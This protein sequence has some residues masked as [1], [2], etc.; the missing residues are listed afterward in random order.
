MHLFANDKCWPR[1]ASTSA[2]A[3]RSTSR[4]SC[5]RSSSSPAAATTPT[6]TPRSRRSRTTWVR[7][8]SPRCTSRARSTSRGRAGQEGRRGGRH[9]GQVARLHQGEQVRRS[10]GAD[11]ERAPRAPGGDGAAVRRRARGAARE[12]GRGPRAARDALVGIVAAGLSGLDDHPRPRRLGGSGLR[13]PGGAA[14]GRRGDRWR[15]ELEARQIGRLPRRAV[16]RGRAL[17]AITRT[18][19]PGGR[20]PR[21]R[22]RGVARRGGRTRS[23]RR[24]PAEALEQW[25]EDAREAHPE[26]FETR[27]TDYLHAK[28]ALGSARGPARSAPPRARST[29]SW[30]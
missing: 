27:R 22:G 8:P 19:R 17:R 4:R 28:M 11:C 13:G 1:S 2:R 26:L 15:G 12:P 9:V 20:V 23:P 14:G 7:P 25:A 18:R 24:R 29:T 21:R 3:R 30:S 10:E 6:S 16:A 5:A